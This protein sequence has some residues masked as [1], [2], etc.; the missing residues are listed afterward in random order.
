MNDAQPRGSGARARAVAASVQPRAQRYDVRYD[1][2]M[3]LCA[4]CGQHTERSGRRRYCS[5]ACRQAAYRQ[6]QPT[7]TAAITAPKRS[8][9]Y[10]CSACGQRLLNERR[11]SDCNLYMSRVGPGGEC[12]HCTEPVAHSDLIP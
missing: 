8:I 12:P 3:L 11:C 1:S 9:V 4:H 6:R 5:D 2:R 10:E 7:A